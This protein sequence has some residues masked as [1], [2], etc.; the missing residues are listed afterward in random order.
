MKRILS[1]ALAYH[2]FVG[3][4]EVAI[5]E[6]TDRLSPSEFQFDMITLRFDRNLPR[7]EIIGNI[8]VHRI[9]FSVPGAK[10]SDRSLPWQCKL[11]KLLFPFT[12]FVRAVRLHSRHK[13]DAAWAMMANQAGFAALFFK[14]AHPRVPYILELQDGRAFSEMKNRRP[15]LH[16]LWPLY[17]EVYFK[18]DRIKV[19]SNFIA[20]EVRAIGYQKTV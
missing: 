1:F 20:K 8:L 13:Y 17:K 2:P 5:K 15:V 19:I 18:A 10:V 16:A 7:E 14:W 4:A 11:A 3:G 9:G 12:A 6:I